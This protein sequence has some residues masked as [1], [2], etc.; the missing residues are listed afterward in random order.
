MRDACSL[1]IG[2]RPSVLGIRIRGGSAE[3]DLAPDGGPGEGGA[4]TRAVSTAEVVQ[5]LTAVTDIRNR[6]VFGESVGRTFNRVSYNNHQRLHSALYHQSPAIFEQ[7][8][9]VNDDLGTSS[10]HRSRESSRA[11]KGEPERPFSVEKPLPPPLAPPHELPFERRVSATGSSDRKRR[12]RTTI[13][14]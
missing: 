8:P 14:W 3:R 2:A 5:L 9:I 1:R 6:C 11:T 4:D 10:D 7:S 13:L 12:K